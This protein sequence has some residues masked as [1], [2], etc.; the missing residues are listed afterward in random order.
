MDAYEQCR[1]LSRQ[2]KLNKDGV[3][4]YN[5]LSKQRLVNILKTK[6]KT[7]FIGAI[8]EIEKTFGYLWG[9]GKQYAELNDNEKEWLN[10][11]NSM[12]ERLLTK[13]NNQIRNMESEMDRHTVIWNT[14]NYNLKIK[15][16]THE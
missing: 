9:H 14:Y 11:W 10:I 8:D 7:V 15:E 4:R 1:E 16:K 13:G 3:K 5:E 12:R 2:Q 6:F